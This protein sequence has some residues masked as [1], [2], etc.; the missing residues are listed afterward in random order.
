M[1][2][3]LWHQQSLRKVKIF[4]RE[5]IHFRKESWTLREIWIYSSLLALT[6]CNFCLKWLRLDRII[7]FFKWEFKFTLW[8]D[9]LNCVT[10]HLEQ[11]FSTTCL[12]NWRTAVSLSI[13]HPQL[14]SGLNV[15]YSIQGL[16]CKGRKGSEALLINIVW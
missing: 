15:V 4:T 7:I 11:N 5:D 1:D 10:Q 12:I 3:G 14:L 2:N 6:L 9:F 16:K 13:E 8:E